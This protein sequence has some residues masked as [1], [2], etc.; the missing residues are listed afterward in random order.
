MRNSM[1]KVSFERDATTPATLD[2][3]NK[4]FADIL[5]HLQVLNYNST[6]V[7]LRSIRLS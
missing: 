2:L 4:T 6:H 7:I 1:P 5:L 3:T